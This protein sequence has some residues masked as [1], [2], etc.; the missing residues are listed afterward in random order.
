MT[1]EKKA[2]NKT[3]IKTN[4]KPRGSTAVSVKHHLESP[5]NIL[6]WKGLQP[7]MIYLRHP[8]GARGSQ[9]SQIS[10]G[11]Y[12]NEYGF[13]ILSLHFSIPVCP[14]NTPILI[15]PFARSIS[16]LHSIQQG[17]L[18]ISYCELF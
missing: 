6:R 7:V 16:P 5:G 14:H 10:D 17:T 15:N 18:L 3:K 12:K 9:R 1:K 8:H 4:I 13:D 11:T 2:N